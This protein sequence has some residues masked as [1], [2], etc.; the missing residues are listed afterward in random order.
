LP[1]FEECAAPAK[2][3][4]IQVDGGQIPI[5]DKDKRS[6]EALSVIVYRPESIQ[7]VDNHHRQIIEKTCVVSVKDE[8]LQSIKTYLINAAIKQ[9]LYRETQVSALADGANNCWSVLLAIRPYCNTL[10]C[11][12]DWFHIAQKFQNVKNAGSIGC[13]MLM[14]K[15]LRKS[16]DGASTNSTTKFTRDCS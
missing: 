4:I 10:E 8:N 5:Q 14:Y 3:L 2:D 16:A 13:S 9:G 12:L 1:V 11:I 6:F 15:A 7:A